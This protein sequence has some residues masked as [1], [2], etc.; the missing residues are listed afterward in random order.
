VDVSSVLNWIIAQNL[1][2]LVRL[3]TQRDAA[4]AIAKTQGVADAIADWLQRV[5]LEDGPDA[6]S[7]GLQDLQQ[8][9]RAVGAH[10][11]ARGETNDGP[12]SKAG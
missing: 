10:L 7:R 11:Q 8:R 9:L 2:V 1:H 4:M 6:A 5:E 3:Q 12:T